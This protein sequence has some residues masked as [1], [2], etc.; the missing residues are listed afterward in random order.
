LAKAFR[1]NVKCPAVLCV[2]AQ[3][4]FIVMEHIDGV[5]AKEAIITEKYGLNEIATK[6]GELIAVCH[7]SDLI[8][9]DL[10]TS[11]ILFRDGEAVLIDFGLAQVSS[12]TE[13]KAVDL[14][15]LERAISS[16]H[17]EASEL[18]SRI[19][20]SYADS[21]DMSSSKIILNKLAE[22]KLFIVD[23]INFCSSIARQEAI[24]GRMRSSLQ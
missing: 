22:G 18:F 4:G 23:L 16:T 14:Y 10:T 11:N 9:G 6:I 12:M 1:A 20:N 8:H 13:D 19:I 21:M 7:A 17:P 24:D 3:N 5:T 2:D 15:V